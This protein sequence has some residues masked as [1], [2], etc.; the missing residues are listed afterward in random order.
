MKLDTARSVYRWTM[1][2]C[3][4]PRKRLQ[5]FSRAPERKLESASRLAIAGYPGNPV[6]SLS[7]SWLDRDGNLGSGSDHELSK[8]ERDAS[9]TGSMRCVYGRFQDSSAR[10][11]VLSDDNA[12]TLSIQ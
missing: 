5:P 6:Q 9:E 11:E 10:F 7:V 12:H 4:F 8:A 2:K 3:G 1:G